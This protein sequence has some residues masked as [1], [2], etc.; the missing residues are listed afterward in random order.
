[1]AA[2]VAKVA[3]VAVANPNPAIPVS[4]ESTDAEKLNANPALEDTFFEDDRRYCGQCGQLT[5]GRCLAAW[6]G[7]I[8][9]ARVYR[10]V[11]TIPRR[12]AGFKP[13]ADDPDQRTGYERWPGLPP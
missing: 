8:T 13:E 6:R 12:C 3:T 5:F 4:D 10:P 9:S 11:D 2:T 7:E 1:M